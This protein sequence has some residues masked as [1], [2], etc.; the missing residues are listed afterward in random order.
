MVDRTKNLCYLVTVYYNAVNGNGEIKSR[1]HC[2]VSLHSIGTKKCQDFARRVAQRDK[3]FYSFPEEW[4]D[5][6]TV[7]NVDY[8][9]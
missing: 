3:Q 7:P 6:Y 9:K 8:C 5:Q 4:L 2:F 1:G